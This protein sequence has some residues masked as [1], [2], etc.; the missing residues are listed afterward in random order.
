MTAP[1][2]PGPVPTPTRRSRRPLI[3]G[4]AVALAV[5]IGALI[6][7]VVVLAGQIHQ[8]P[9]AAE[10]PSAAA[11]EPEQAR[12]ETLPDPT[13]GPTPSAADF[14]LTPKITDQEC[15]GSAG[16]NVVFHVAMDYTG[17]V[18]SES[19]TWLITYEARGGEDGPLIGTLRL[20][21]ERFDANNETVSTASSAKK[22]SI[23]VTDVQ[24][25]L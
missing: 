23:K 11:A 25:D 16:C 1:T 20:R 5:L 22:I 21:G 14:T 13:P 24:K 4:A 6:T 2:T 9:T 12:Q 17:P 19:D 18:L 7:T 8:A 10:Q 15:F 3:I